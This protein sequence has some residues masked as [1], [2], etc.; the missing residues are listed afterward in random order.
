MV[1]AATG[2][3]AP[4]PAAAPRLFILLVTTLSRHL[5]TTLTQPLPIFQRDQNW[6]V[7]PLQNDLCTMLL[8]TKAL[9][10]VANH[11]RQLKQPT[12]DYINYGIFSVSNEIL[13]WL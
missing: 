1:A 9:V 13:Q 7:V 3:V 6:N 5:V 4:L 12:E 2:P 11:G 10:V 8:F